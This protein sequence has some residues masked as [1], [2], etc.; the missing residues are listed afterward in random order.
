MK[1]THATRFAIGLLT[2][3]LLAAGAA[4]QAQKSSKASLKTVSCA[5]EC[6]FMVSSHDEQEV[7]DIVKAHAKQK[8]EKEMTDDQVREMI[9]TDQSKSD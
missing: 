9:K 6:G 4:Q 2:V 3:G 8:H 7:I 1:T 5:P